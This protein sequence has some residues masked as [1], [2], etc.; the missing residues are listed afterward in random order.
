MA[1]ITAADISKLRGMTGAGL[2]D[3]KGALTEAEGDFDKAIE[4]LRKKGQKIASKRQDRDA[5]EGCVLSGVTADG[6]TAV[7]VCVNCE[8]DFV[9]KNGDFIAFTQSVLDVAMNVL[10]A[11]AEELKQQ[12]IG[13]RKI[14][15]LLTD[16]MG[17]IGEKIDL[18][19]Y[20]KVTSEHSFA[21]THMGNKLATIVGFD[22]KVADAQVGKDVAMQ[23]AAMNPV[24]VDQ[25]DVPQ[26]V[27]D[28]EIEIAKEKT[29]QE[30]IQKAIDVE[31]KKA[32]INPNHVDSEDHMASNAAKG[33][34][35]EEQVEQAKAII[36]K[37]TEEKKNSIPAAMI[38][39]IAK[40]RLNK[41]F[42]ESTL[43]NQEFVKD[44]KLT[45]AQYIE[46]AQKGLKVT[47]FKRFGLN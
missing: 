40:G 31:L 19:C 23:V 15:D 24:A 38:E 28:T 44:S 29:V 43:M 2:M 46:S 35:T 3:C 27:I 12:E 30:Q 26:S 7:I 45:I 18:G 20:E 11:N 36:A 17:K 9:A 8:T 32:G 14:A 42:K 22:A 33:W 37:V 39:N 21:Y 4:I 47:S 5:K 6:K 34:I 16:Q 10:P 1:N 13:G 41:F 25:K